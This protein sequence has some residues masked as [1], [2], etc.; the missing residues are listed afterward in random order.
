MR[1]LPLLKW[2]ILHGVRT[3]WMSPPSGDVM[4]GH[5]AQMSHDFLETASGQNLLGFASSG[6]GG[7]V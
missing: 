1:I 2:M 5:L 6:P 3:P 7:L 4:G